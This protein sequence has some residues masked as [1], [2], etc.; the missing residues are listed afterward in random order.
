M[1]TTTFQGYREQLTDLQ[2]RLSRVHVG[3]S[4]EIQRVT[5]AITPWLMLADAQTR[6]RVVGLWG[7]TGTGK[8]SLVRALVR[9]LAL[10]DRTFWLDVSR[11]PRRSAG[12]T[13]CSN[14]LR[15]TTTAR[16]SSSWWTSS[17]MRVRCGQEWS[18]RS[19][20]N[21]VACGSLL[22]LVAL[23]WMVVA[24]GASPHCWISTTTSLLRSRKGWW[25][26]MAGW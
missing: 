4:P 6:P 23:C 8:S 25:C 13:A 11:M 5:A 15:N 3:L 19:R 18:R 7:M 10:E 2:A 12:W 17:S 26:A 1:N 24:D 16:L 21:S 22:M 20:E 9:E 14:G